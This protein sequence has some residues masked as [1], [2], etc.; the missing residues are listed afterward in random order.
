MDLCFLVIAHPH[1]IIFQI[2]LFENPKLIIIPVFSIETPSETNPRELFELDCDNQ[3]ANWR[4]I[5][6]NHHVI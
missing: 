3:I 1:L 6:N 5:N 4:G 2:T